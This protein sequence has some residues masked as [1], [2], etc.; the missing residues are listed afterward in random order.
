MFSA[1]LALLV[2]RPTA[3]D[4]SYLKGYQFRPIS[5]VFLWMFVAPTQK[6]QN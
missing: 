5:K 1:I 3:E 4:L 6:G 2:H